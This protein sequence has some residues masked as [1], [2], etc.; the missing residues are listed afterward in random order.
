MGKKGIV[1]VVDA[2][3]KVSNSREKGTSEGTVATGMPVARHPPHR[4]RRAV[5]RK[6]MM[7]D[8]YV[9]GIIMIRT[10]I[11][12]TQQEKSELSRFAEV[13]GKSQSEII[14]AAID[15]LLRRRKA[16]RIP[17]ILGKTAGIWKGRSDLPDFSA[18]RNGW[19]REGSR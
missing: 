3:K 15:S 11:Y 16:S 8:V 13:T 10:Q 9:G 5:D 2:G 4:S 18:L 19:N 17:D 14:R 6:V 1:L 7:Y 12:L